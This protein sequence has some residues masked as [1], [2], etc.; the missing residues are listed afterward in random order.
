VAGAE[1]AAVLHRRVAAH[2]E[3]LVVVG[4]GLTPESRTRA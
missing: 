2:A 1:Q 4:V 3:W